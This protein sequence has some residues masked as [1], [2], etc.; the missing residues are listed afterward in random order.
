MA[1][2]KKVSLKRAREGDSGLVEPNGP[3]FPHSLFLDDKDISKLGVGD[4][5]LGDERVLVA[6]IRVTSLST[7]EREDEG[8]DQRMTLDLIEGEVGQPSKSQAERLFGGGDGN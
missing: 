6:T 4:L 5:K 8:K 1:E 7:S 2:H 3:Y